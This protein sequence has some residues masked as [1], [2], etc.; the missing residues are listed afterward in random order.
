[1]RAT[2]TTE[3]RRRAI[4][5]L[6]VSAV[7]LGAAVIPAQADVISDNPAFAQEVVQ[8]EQRLLAE[9][10]RGGFTCGTHPVARLGCVDASGTLWTGADLA[11]IIDHPDWQALAKRAPAGFPI[12]FKVVSGA[13]AVTARAK[14]RTKARTSKRSTK[15]P[16]T[17]AKPKHR[18]SRAR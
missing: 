13:D 10:G 9:V 1:M 4:A 17:A 5:T 18:N 14:A 12:A 6:A 2:I 7:A 8:T 11:A 3:R 16:R 15:A